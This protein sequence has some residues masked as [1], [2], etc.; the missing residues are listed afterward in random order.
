MELGMVDVLLGRLS[1]SDQVEDRYVV[2]GIGQLDAISYPNML[3][4]SCLPLRMW[5]A[6]IDASDFAKILK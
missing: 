5:S 6:C 3:P 1:C 4:R 2:I